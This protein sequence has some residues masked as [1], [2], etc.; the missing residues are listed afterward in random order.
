[1]C[2]VVLDP[3]KFCKFNEGEG[4]ARLLNNTSEKGSEEIGVVIVPF[5][6]DS[7]P[8]IPEVFQLSSLTRS[9]YCLGFNMSC[10][11]LSNVC[12]NLVTLLSGG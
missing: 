9:P 12:V 7:V 11:S 6:S 8:R 10:I 4:N 5:L 1:M 2:T 3:L